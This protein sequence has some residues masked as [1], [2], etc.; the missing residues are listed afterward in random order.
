MEIVK[1]KT[2]AFTGN[3][4]LTSP[5]GLTGLDLQSAIIH[6][7]Y[8][9]IEREHTENGVIN[10]MTGMAMGLDFLAGLAIT[11]VRQQYPAIRFIAVIPFQGH[12]KSFTTQEKPYHANLCQCADHLI[13]ISET[14][15]TPAYHQRNDFLIANASKIIAYHNGKPRSGAGSTIR[16]A[17]EIG[18]EVT[19]LYADI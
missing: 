2:I 17:T 11:E 16:K 18:I 14:P 8:E 10:F 19:N 9:I 4:N 5:S 13:T 3:R 7:L 1:S 6:K 12:H 15:G